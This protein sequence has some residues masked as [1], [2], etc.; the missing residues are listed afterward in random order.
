MFDPANPR[1][2][3]FWLPL[4]HEFVAAIGAVAAQ[5]SY[6]DMQFDGVTTFL[7]RSPECEKIANPRPYSFSKR[8]KLFRNLARLN[9]ENCAPLVEKLSSL[10]I[11]A[12]DLCQKRNVVVHGF[13]FDSRWADGYITLT[14]KADGT[15]DIYSVD[16][17]DVL[18]LARN[19]ADLRT[20]LVAF[21]FADCH[22]E[23][24]FATPTEQSVLQ[25]YRRRYPDP[26]QV[27]PI[28]RDPRR[29]GT[30]QRPEPFRA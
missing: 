11:R 18:H 9:F 19:I 12:H 21:I 13:W 3:A 7:S 4:P 10:S 22:G 25:E 23:S 16:L 15:G 24:Q 1:E 5:W 20:E 27:L 17:P 8:A 28:P 2:K 29:V 26:P 14:S 6:F 30:P